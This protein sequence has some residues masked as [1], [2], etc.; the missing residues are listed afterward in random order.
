MESQKQ[1]MD[2]KQAEGSDKRKSYETP[3]LTKLGS[4]EQLTRGVTG[5]APDNVTTSVV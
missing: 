2:D 3:T 5:A 1:A 4:V